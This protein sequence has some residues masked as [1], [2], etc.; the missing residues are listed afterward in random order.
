MGSYGKLL[1]LAC[2]L[3]VAACSTGTGS[4]PV[5][6]SST[7]QAV[8]TVVS[9]P[10]RLAG[11]QASAQSFVPAPSASNTEQTQMNAVPTRAA[12]YVVENGG[13]APG[14][15]LMS[16]SVSNAVA[17]DNLLELLI[18]GVSYVAAGEIGP[19][20]KLVFKGTTNASSVSLF[21]VDAYGHVFLN[22]LVRDDGTTGE[23][24]F[25]FDAI[26]IPTDVAYLDTQAAIP[27]AYAT[28]DGKSYLIAS[29]ADGSLRT[30]DGN[31]M[32]FAHFDSKSFDGSM[33]LAFAGKGAKAKGTEN[34]NITFSGVISGNRLD[35]PS[36]VFTPGAEQVGIVD[37]QQ[38]SGLSAEF[39][40]PAA[41]NVGG[42]FFV[43]GPAVGSP[44]QSAVVQGGFIGNRQ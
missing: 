22:S 13:R 29:G 17:G 44:T 5:T 25:G 2:A 35:A 34:V 37:S 10:T 26:G 16:V 14:V 40:G 15:R 4:G 24:A 19:N 8:T 28:Y 11:V 6:T 21:P 1:A 33:D 18:D 43:T 41:E 7:G 20:G 9:T 36:I 27:G 3:G 38:K 39:F 32:L 42:Q 30:A 23:I 31:L 12:S